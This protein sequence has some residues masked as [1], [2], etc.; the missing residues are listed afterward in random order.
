MIYSGTSGSGPKNLEKAIDQITKTFS[1]VK[2]L[3]VGAQKAGDP[4]VTAVS[5]SEI[6]P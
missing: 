1:S 2:R 3:K 4:S 6:V 5:V